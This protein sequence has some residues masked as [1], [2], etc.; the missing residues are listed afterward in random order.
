MGAFMIFSMVATMA[1]AAMSAKAQMQTAKQQQANLEYNAKVQ[2]QAAQ[3]ET[4]QRAI[5]A[6]EE[7]NQS[8]R[9]LASMEARYAKAGLLMAGT[10]ELMMQTQAET[11][12]FNILSK[13]RASNIRTQN[14]MTDA[15]MMRMQGEDARSAGKTG[16]FT[17]LLGGAASTASM[18]YNYQSRVG[19][20]T[21]LLNTPDYSNPMAAS[22]NSSLYNTN[23]MFA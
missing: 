20:K 10:P 14:L 12:E 16:A 2:E 6:T 22:R 7:R 17:T 9:R 13:D 3:E 15:E 1:S 11:D 21:S 8:R 4:A 5:E 23:G 19:Q 18:G